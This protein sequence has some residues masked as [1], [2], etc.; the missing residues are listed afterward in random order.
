MNIIKSII[1]FAL[2]G[3][4]DMKVAVVLSV[5]TTFEVCVGKKWHHPIVHLLKTSFDRTMI[6]HPHSSLSEIYFLITDSF[7]ESFI[8]VPIF[9]KWRHRYISK[10]TNI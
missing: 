7:E 10:L 8:P 6:G 5:H 9:R 2:D 3:I 4:I 1:S